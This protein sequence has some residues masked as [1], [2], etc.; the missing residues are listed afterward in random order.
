MK[1]APIPSGIRSTRTAFTLVELL[2]VIAIIGVLVSLLLPAVQAA[3][4]AARRSS[5]TNNLKQIGVAMHN[6]ENSHKNYPPSM[7]WRY[8]KRPSEWS[9]QAR[10]LPFLEQAQLED[11]IDYEED[12][13]TLRLSSDPAAP[14]ISSFRIDVYLCPTEERDEPRMENGENAQYPLNYGFN[15]GVWR[16]YTPTQDAVGIGGPGVLYPNSHLRPAQIS[17]GLSN[18]LMAAE[19]KGYTPYFRDSNTT[20]PA[21]TDPAAICGLGG[22]FKETSGHTEWVDGRVHQTGFTALFTPNTSVECVQSGERFDVDWTS[23]REGQTQTG[24]TLAAVTSRSYHPGVVNVARMD[25]SV[26]TIADGVEL[27][28]WQAMA[29]RNG[30]EVSEN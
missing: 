20:P 7:S 22:N 23:A 30:G 14:L 15:F 12:Y 27:S 8:G 17:D 26:E 24:P 19:V 11:A 5:C 18:T 10:I 29:T 13:E 16:V 25:G 28:V 3:R 21:P 2:V 1:A 6:F 9:A 4:E